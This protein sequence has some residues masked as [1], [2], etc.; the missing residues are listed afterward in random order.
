M[1]A[2]KIISA[3]SIAMTTLVACSP[4]AEQIVNDQQYEAPDDI[5]LA[6]ARQQHGE[7]VYDPVE[8]FYGDF[9]GDGLDDALAWIL[10]PSGGNSDFLDVALFRNED[11]FIVYY[12]SINDV[13]G[14]NPRDVVFEHGRITLTTTMPAPGDA[15]CCPTGSERWII[16]TF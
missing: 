1:V 6:W 12:R 15:R 2:S 7:D 3:L 14:G 13:F 11:G 8:T 10:Y 9:T 4:D 16:D 5:I